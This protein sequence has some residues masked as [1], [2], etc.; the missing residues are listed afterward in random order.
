MQLTF[1][2]ESGIENDLS[3]LAGKPLIVHFYA[4]WCGPCMREMP[5]LANEYMALQTM[6]YEIICLTDDNLDAVTRIK[7]S[8]PQVL[9]IYRLKGSLQDAG[10]Y[11]IPQTFVFKKDGTLAH[12]LRGEAAWSNPEWH[13]FLKETANK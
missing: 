13:T 7:N 12:H 4:S 8:L 10:I 1:L 3:L 5:S 2:D 6:G 9:P 11:N